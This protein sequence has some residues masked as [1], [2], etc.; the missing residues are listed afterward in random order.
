MN[1]LVKALVVAAVLAGV[2]LVVINSKSTEE[3][4]RTSDGP[5][6]AEV[7]DNVPEDN[8]SPVKASPTEL[9]SASG[10]VTT[11]DG[12]GVAGASSSTSSIG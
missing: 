4:V 5:S 3:P 2:F 7:V 8:R 9:A 12:S 1:N 10:T 11:E 6:S